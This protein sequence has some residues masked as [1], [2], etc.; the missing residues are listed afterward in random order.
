MGIVS[1][2]TTIVIQ[3]WTQDNSPL[4]Q[5]APFSISVTTSSF[6]IEKNSGS[7]LPIWKIKTDSV[8]E[9]PHL[10]FT[11]RENMKGS[12][13]VQKITVKSGGHT[14]NDRF[15]QIFEFKKTVFTVP[16]IPSFKA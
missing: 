4:A 13:N 14:E 10:S 11:A 3:S 15:L 12:K 6:Q 5:S 16:Y 9:R 1:V 8:L 2:L 7:R